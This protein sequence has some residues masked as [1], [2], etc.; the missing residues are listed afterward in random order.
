MSASKVPVTYI[1]KKKC[2]EYPTIGGDRR[3]GF[4]SEETI[5]KIVEGLMGHSSQ[6]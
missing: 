2:L 6:D 3:K 4:I 1:Q 5:V